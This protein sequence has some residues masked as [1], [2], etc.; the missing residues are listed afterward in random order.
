MNVSTKKV[1]KANEQTENLVQVFDNL[2]LCCVAPNKGF[3]IA[4]VHSAATARHTPVN[5]FS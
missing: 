3:E 4:A 1:L 2:W 5:P